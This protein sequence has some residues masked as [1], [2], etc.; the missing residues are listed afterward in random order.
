[1]IIGGTIFFS[2]GKMKVGGLNLKMERTFYWGINNC[3]L[4]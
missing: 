1:M 2:G 4:I 3:P